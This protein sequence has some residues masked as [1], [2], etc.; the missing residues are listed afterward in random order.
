MLLPS[1]SPKEFLP[2]THPRPMTRARYERLVLALRAK[3]P[4]VINCLLNPAPGHLIATDQFLRQVETVVPHE[5]LADLAFLS[6]TT[7]SNVLTISMELLMV[8]KAR[9]EALEAVKTSCT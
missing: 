9:S 7:V 1:E 4:W 8:S 2:F 6:I 5:D 3:H